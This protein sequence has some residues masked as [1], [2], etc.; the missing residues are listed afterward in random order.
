MLNIIK[1]KLKNTY[2]K[3]PLNNIN[4]TI[5]NKNFIP[6]VRDWKNSIYVYNKNTLSLIPVASKLIMKLI[7][8][9]FNSYN[10][11]MELKIRKEKLRR[12]LRKLSTNKIFISNGEFKH[13]NDKVNITLYVYNRQKLNYLLKLKKRYIKLFKKA[14]FIRKLELIKNAGLNILKNKQEES[15][16]LANILHNSNSM[17]YSVQNVYY[18]KFIKKFLK[19][20]NI[21]CFINNYFIL[22]NLNLKILI[23]KV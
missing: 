12:R 21:I 11:S 18:K 4:V 6:V 22:I 3:K 16:I 9:Y 7:K 1:S 17:L 8:G 5:S 10:L 15:K 2:K 23:Y 19:D 13:T 14:G 20:W